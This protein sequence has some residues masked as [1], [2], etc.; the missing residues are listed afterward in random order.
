MP[1]GPLL[2]EKKGTNLKSYSGEK[3]WRWD[4][5]TNQKLMVHKFKICEYT[6]VRSVWSGL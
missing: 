5:V 2:I 3:C 6:Q 4:F 1:A